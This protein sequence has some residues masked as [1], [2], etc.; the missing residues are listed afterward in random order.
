MVEITDELIE[1]TF[2]AIGRTRDVLAQH[3][4]PPPLVDSPKCVGCSLVG[5]CLPDEVN[6]LNSARKEVLRIRVARDD[7]APLHVQE[8]GARVGL[9]GDCLVVRSRSGE[10]LTARLVHT[11]NVCVW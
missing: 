3:E 7:C 4:C 5:I 2:T 11:S 6:A 9:S 10:E 8:Q 1:M